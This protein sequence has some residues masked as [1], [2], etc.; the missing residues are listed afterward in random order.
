MSPRRR[1]MGGDPALDLFGYADA[2]PPAET[3]VAARATAAD[4]GDAPRSGRRS[5]RAAAATE[6]LSSLRIAEPAPSPS[7]EEGIPGA[8][9]ASAVSV[10][11]LTHTAKDVL[12]GAFVPLWVRG[13]VSDF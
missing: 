12:E 7:F 4:E 11:T 9:P 10:A 5:R 6:E 3:P 1:T 8:S 13:E 2:A